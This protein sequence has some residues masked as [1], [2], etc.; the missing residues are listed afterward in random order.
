[1]RKI[2]SLLLLSA[3]AVFAQKLSFDVAS[4]KPAPPLNPQ[5]ILAGGKL[6]VGMQVDASRAPA[7][8]TPSVTLDPR[9]EERLKKTKELFD[10][11]LINEEE[12][13]QYRTEILK[14]L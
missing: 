6:H 13:R 14:D 10:R 8:T 1:M 4:I 11:G 2:A 7:P 9:V 5:S 3:V 12:Y